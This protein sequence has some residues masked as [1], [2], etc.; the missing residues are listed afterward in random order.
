MLRFPKAQVKAGGRQGGTC[1]KY[2]YGSEKRRVS[3]RVSTNERRRMPSAQGREQGGKV[4]CAQ[5][6]SLARCFAT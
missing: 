2:A 1:T 6:N 5:V 3:W 4:L